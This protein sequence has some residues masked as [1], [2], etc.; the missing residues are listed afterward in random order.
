MYLPAKKGG[1]QNQRA[2]PMLL[3]DIWRRENMHAG[4]NKLD[5]PN[6][7]ATFASL[8]G[9]AYKRRNAIPATTPYFIRS[10]SI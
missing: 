2:A 6:F 4:E 5:G 7:R 10:L 3:D 1:G 8:V 9:P